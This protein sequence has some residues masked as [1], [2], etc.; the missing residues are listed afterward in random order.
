MVYLYC[1]CNIKQIFFN[2]R[3]HLSCLD[4]EL[5]MFRLKVVRSLVMMRKCNNSLLFDI[6]FSSFIVLG[7]LHNVIYAGP[8]RTRKLNL[9]VSPHTAGNI[10]FGSMFFSCPVL[11]S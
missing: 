6:L 9:E 3:G 2:K 5:P 8:N 10:E 11:P 7:S 4:V 1:V